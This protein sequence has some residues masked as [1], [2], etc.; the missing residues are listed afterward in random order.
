MAATVGF[1]VIILKFSLD[2]LKEYLK[3]NKNNIDGKLILNLCK[4]V[5]I[6]FGRLIPN[7]PDVYDN[8]GTI[9]DIGSLSKSEKENILNF[10]ETNMRFR[11]NS[12]AHTIN[13]IESGDDAED[14]ISNCLNVV[15]HLDE[16]Y[17][18]LKTLIDKTG[19]DVDNIGENIH[20]T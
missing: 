2:C 3:K 11:R 5:Y 14:Y 7:D 16:I 4:S 18:I 1:N 20:S 15:K 13:N 10:Y 6:D 12:I 8:I 19:V 9:D 17:N